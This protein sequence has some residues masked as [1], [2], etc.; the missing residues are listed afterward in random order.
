MENFLNRLSESICVWDHNKNLL[1]IN[2]STL[3]V[4]G[5]KKD[6]LFEYPINEIIK[7]EDNILGKAIYG[8]TVEGNW[9]RGNVE[10]AKMQG[11][12]STKLYGII[13]WNNSAPYKGLKDIGYEVNRE[14]AN[15]KETYNKKNNMTL[16]GV[17]DLEP[18]LKICFCTEQVNI[19]IY[20]RHLNQI[21]PCLETRMSKAILGN[22]KGISMRS[23]DI[24][25]Y[26]DGS[27]ER[28]QRAKERYYMNDHTENAEE[29]GNKYLVHYPIIYKGEF[30]G[31]L[32]MT[33]DEYP[34]DIFLKDNWVNVICKQ[35][36]LI[37]KHEAFYEEEFYKR[38]LVE[39]TIKDVLKMYIDWTV[40]IDQE[41]YYKEVS[42]NSSQLLGWSED[43]LLKMKWQDHIHPDDYEATKKFIAAYQEN[44]RGEDIT[45]H[46]SLINRYRCKDGTYKWLRWDCYLL[47]ES[48]NLI[49]TAKDI[50]YEKEK[51]IKKEEA[52]KIKELEHIRNEFFANISHEFKTPLTIIMSVIQVLEL[53]INHEQNGLVKDPGLEKYMSLIK[54][55]SYRLLR[56]VNNLIDITKIDAGQCHLKLNNF[57]IVNVVEE[58]VLAAVSNIQD[59]RIDL[60]FDTEVEEE[61][62]ACDPEKIER[63][64]LN[65]LSNA[66]KYTGGEGIIDVNLKLEEEMVV[67][68]VEDNGMGI[69]DNKVDLIFERFI[70]GYDIMT[71]HC[72]GSGIGLS[73]VRSMVEMHGGNVCVRSKEGQ[74][75]RFE[76]R[77]P[78][79]KIEGE[80]ETRLEAVRNRYMQ[81]ERAYIEFSGI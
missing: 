43:E 44:G 17:K 25:K 51:E 6:K 75:A 45:L 57:N 56:L 36:S 66:V 73:V 50:T 8:K 52:R 58:I 54:K 53:S 32:G 49:G 3:D 41:G 31:L 71:R 23:E 81:L 64:I 26:L 79:V 35:I 39:D 34:G 9:I 30:L 60:T 62:I 47:R 1:F 37:I 68:I 20:N 12:E 46:K 76:V 27:F 13:T 67:V 29:M 10:I 28:I 11:E 72:E 74:G 80:G 40:E 24:K 78:R 61:I 22:K 65:L 19:W 59:K 4:L 48:S 2:D 33:Y 18:I 38:F 42:T 63:V 15:V 7:I 70:Q 55:N 21:E 16:E 5:Y 77:L 14:E 69:P